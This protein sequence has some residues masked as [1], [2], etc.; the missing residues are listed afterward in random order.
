MLRRTLLALGLVVL[1]VGLLPLL[2]AESAARQ[3]AWEQGC[4]KD[5][6]SITTKPP[7]LDNPLVVHTG[8]TVYECRGVDGTLLSRRD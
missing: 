8:H 2:R 4:G 5:G 7:Q 6:G 1:L 3:R